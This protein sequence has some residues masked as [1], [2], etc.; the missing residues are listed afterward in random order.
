MDD[1]AVARGDAGADAGGGFRNDHVV[2]G[3]RGRACDR[4][5]HH[6]RSD[7]QD[8][9]PPGPLYLSLH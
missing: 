9:H 2:P 3:E 4:K 6:A 8:L 1:F 5:P 7:H